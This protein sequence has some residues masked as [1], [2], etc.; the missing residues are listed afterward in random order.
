MH[1][2]ISI[3]ANPFVQICTEVD[4]FVV[5]TQ[6]IYSDQRFNLS[7][8]SQLRYIVIPMPSVELIYSLLRIYDLISDMLRAYYLKYLCA[9]KLKRFY[10][11]LP[12]RLR[13]RR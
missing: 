5:T 8:M 2:E 13:F 12:M 6:T 3:N 1:V 11:L 10:Y 7:K 9:N 4:K